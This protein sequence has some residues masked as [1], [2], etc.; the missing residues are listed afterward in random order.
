M[1]LG[2]HEV[3]V[4]EVLEWRTA[5]QLERR[6]QARRRPGRISAEQTFAGSHQSLELRN[7]IV[8]VVDLESIAGTHRVQHRVAVPFPIWLE[9]VAQPGD[10]H[11]QRVQLAGGLVPPEFLEHAIG[12][13]RLVAMDQ[14]QREHGLLSVRTEIEFLAVL[15]HREGTE[16]PKLHVGHVTTVRL[17]LD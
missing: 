12:G 17:P 8:F 1:C 2:L 3:V 16:R 9:R 11:T 10:V 14:K 5:P 7:V 13:Q 4:A 6:L 15:Q